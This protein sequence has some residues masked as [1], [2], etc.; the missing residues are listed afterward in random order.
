MDVEVISDSVQQ[1]SLKLVFLD[2]NKTLVITLIYAKCDERERLQLWEDIY[3]VAGSTNSPWLV[4][5]DFNVVLHEDEKIGGIPVQPQDY[6]DFAFCVNSCELL[7][8]GFKG[9]HFTWWNGR[10]EHLA[11][12]G[13]DH[14]PLLI[15]LKEQEWFSNRLMLNSKSIYTLRRN[16]GGKK[17]NVTWFAE[18]DRNS[19]FFHNLVNGRRKRLLVKRIQNAN[20]DWLEEAS[21]MAREAESFFKKILTGGGISDFSL[22]NHIQLCACGPDGFSGAFFQICWNIVGVDVFNIVKAF[23]EGF[24]LPK[25]V[26]HTNGVA[27]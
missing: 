12:T 8:T 4:G 9:S 17:A 14:A 26:T 2:L 13:S 19:R 16:S 6:E 25:S 27:A 22:P 1:V 10:G 23:C 15:S 11:R 21:D 20:S 5:G 3:D 7:E 18:D 24:T